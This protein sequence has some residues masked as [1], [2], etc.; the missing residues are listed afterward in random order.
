MKIGEGGIKVKTGDK[1]N[2]WTIIFY[3]WVSFTV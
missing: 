2:N 3:S 1:D